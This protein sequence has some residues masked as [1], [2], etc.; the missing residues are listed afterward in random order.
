MASQ[1]QLDLLLNGGVDAWNAQRELSIAV[2][3][4]LSDADLSGQDLAG[5]NLSR[6]N[7]QNANFTGSVLRGAD[8]GGAQLSGAS[9]LGADLKEANLTSAILV[10]TV[11]SRANL[12]EADI[13]GAI[14][15][16]TDITGSDFTGAELA[17]TNFQDTKVSIST[18]GL[19]EL[20]E[21]QRGGLV[22]ADTLPHPV[23]G[24]GRED[25]ASEGEAIFKGLTIRSIQPIVAAA[26]YVFENFQ[27]PNDPNVVTNE[28]QEL[29]RTLLANITTLNGEIERLN[30]NLDQL[31]AENDALKEQIAKGLPLW[32]K[33]WHEF[34]LDSVRFASKGSTFALGF[35]CGA[36]SQ[37]VTK[38]VVGIPV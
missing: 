33:A 36:L 26:F 9:F 17:N 8:F 5:V 3:I 35:A 22:A 4:D 7:L 23:T 6:A 29:I 10:G 15:H 1:E 32:K 16:E 24:V 28:H 25:G 19:N 13:R 30:E 37:S 38:G 18:I 21:A 27:P 11:L 14:L 20:S 2:P 12:Q 34:V 31:V